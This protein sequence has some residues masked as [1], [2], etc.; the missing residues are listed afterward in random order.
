MRSLVLNGVKPNMKLVYVSE[1]SSVDVG[2]NTI[3]IQG[4]LQSTMLIL[5]SILCS[6]Y[7]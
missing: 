1:T 5:Y 7:I 4:I 6:Y 3:E 2:Q